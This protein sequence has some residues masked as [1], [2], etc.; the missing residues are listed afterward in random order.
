MRQFQALPRT[1]TTMM[2]AGGVRDYGDAQQANSNAR[3]GLIGARRRVMF[4][5]ASVCDAGTLRIR[6]KTAIESRPATLGMRSPAE[7][8]G[9]ARARHMAVAVS[10]CGSR[11]VAPASRGPG[12]EHL[13][14]RA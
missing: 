12:R 14:G 3:R 10:H 9:Q 13:T 1:T 6:R 11:D 7:R 8:A 5:A 2:L 4:A